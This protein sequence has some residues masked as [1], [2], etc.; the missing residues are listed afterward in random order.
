M[1]RLHRMSQCINTDGYDFEKMTADEAVDLAV[2]FSDINLAITCNHG[3]KHTF[4]M[5]PYWNG[6]KEE[7]K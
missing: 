2:M 1:K 4:D 6:H 3:W 7:E 5:K